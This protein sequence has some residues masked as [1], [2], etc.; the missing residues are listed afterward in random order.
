MTNYIQYTRYNS[1]WEVTVQIIKAPFKRQVCLVFFQYLCSHKHNFE[2]D[3]LASPWY[4]GWAVDLWH[5]TYSTCVVNNSYNES[6]LKF[7]ACHNH[8]VKVCNTSFLSRL[9]EVLSCV[10]GTFINIC[11]LALLTC[12]T[13]ISNYCFCFQ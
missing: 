10:L 7:G 2:G 1:T 4:I 5:L 6:K 13:G 3:I 9:V 11:I 12:E 8:D